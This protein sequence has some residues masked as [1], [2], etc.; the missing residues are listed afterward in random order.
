MVVLEGLLMAKYYSVVYNYQIFFIHSSLDG[1]L[2]LGYGKQ[3]CN[4][5][6]GTCIL[7]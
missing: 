4:E 1:N 7:S 2:Y 3:L 5:H 6:W